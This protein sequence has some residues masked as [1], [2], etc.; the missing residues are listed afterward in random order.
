L[1]SIENDGAHPDEH[2]IRDGAGVN[3]RAVTDGD[4]GAD[5]RSEF[6]VEVDDSAVLNIG[7]LAD[8]DAI[9]VAAEH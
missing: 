6:A 9:D 3:D 4:I 5:A 8:D 2:F 1:R 7:A